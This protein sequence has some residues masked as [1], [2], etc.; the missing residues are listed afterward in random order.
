MLRWREGDDSEGQAETPPPGRGGRPDVAGQEGP[1]REEQP[2]EGGE[3]AREGAG[4]WSPPR[5]YWAGDGP[6][7]DSAYGSSG[8]SQNPWPGPPRNTPGSR[9][10]AVEEQA[11]HDLL[12]EVD[13][14]QE[15]WSDTNQLGEADQSFFTAAAALHSAT[16][17]V[18]PDPDGDTYM[19]YPANHPARQ[20]TAAGIRDLVVGWMGEEPERQHYPQAPAQPD[21]GPIAPLSAEILQTR[22]FH[23]GAD[24]LLLLLARLIRRPVALIIRADCRY[25]SPTPAV[26]VYQ[27]GAQN[28]LPAEVQGNNIVKLDEV[29]ATPRP[30][31][32]TT[33]QS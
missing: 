30:S 6:A 16:R 14:R 17:G 23:P 20:F 28:W 2:Q 18:P 26:R 7:T 10:R 3:G 27:P 11:Y 21:G 32:T 25:L 15:G 33:Q 9:A 1:G 8:D 4:S 22:G 13:V 5:E 31:C 19:A 24:C 29:D 12:L